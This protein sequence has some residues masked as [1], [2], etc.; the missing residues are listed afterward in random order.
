MKPG[1]KKN[2]AVIFPVILVLI[3]LVLFNDCS[4][5]K[6]LSR[7]QLDSIKASRKDSL[8]AKALKDSILKYKPKHPILYSILKVKGRSTAYTLDS[9]Y[10]R[11]GRETILAIN[12]I[13][14]RNLR[15]GDSIVIPDRILPLISYSPYPF[16]I[17]RARSVKKLIILS[18]T[19]QAFAAYENGVLIK[20]GPTSTGSKSKPTPEGL[21]GLNWKKEKTTSTIDS[22]WILP[23]YFNFENFEGAA[24]HQ[25]ELPGYPASHACVRL[26]EHD[27]KW[28]YNW[29]QQW[30][31]SNDGEDVV[32]YGTPVIVFDDY[33]FGETPPWKFLPQNPDIVT[34]T[35]E[36]VDDL[37]DDYLEIILARQVKR[38]EIIA[39]RENKK[40]AKKKG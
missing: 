26:L 20:W 3:S 37:M 27:A 14:S 10:G 38:A 18:R 24:F 29:G 16:V 19:I 17:E 2:I 5:E 4:R 6:S 39:E 32:A 11:A 23:F 8:K 31:V 34:I 9:K 30:L 22:S 12:R 33:D 7:Q 21:F 25:Y 40:E 28:I 36:Q 1:I 13:D 35:D 15:R